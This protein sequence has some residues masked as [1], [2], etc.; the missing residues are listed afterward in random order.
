MLSSLRNLVGLTVC[1]ALALSACQVAPSLTKPAP[2]AVLTEQTNTTHSDSIT[3]TL[4]T[5]GA[6]L[7]PQPFNGKILQ[8][9]YLS[10]E[11]FPSGCESVSAVMLLQY[12][13][14]DISVDAFVDGYLPIG[15]K[16][17]KNGDVFGPSPNDQYIG[18][19]R[20]I[21]YGCYAPVIEKAL[22]DILP[23]NSVKNLTGKT[24]VELCAYIDQG[25]PLLVWATIGMEQAF[26]N[27]W[28]T[29]E[30]SGE[31]VEWLA[32]E[33]CMVLVG[34]D[35]DYYY[36]N[37]PYNGNGLMA[38]RRDILEDRFHQMG[39]QAVAILP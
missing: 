17:W 26:P 25:I 28:W 22:Q 8:V 34:Y 39:C 38:Y 16:F 37:D 6:T 13:G 5:T 11:G 14:V 36:C 31:P 19:P 4:P 30:R 15:Q 27:D 21:G 33:H 3:H 20:A 1:I 29:D 35:K 23:H 7:P 32:N 9:P 24:L 12:W 18:D 10:Q 2:T